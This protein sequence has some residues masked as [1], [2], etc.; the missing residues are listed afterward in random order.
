MKKRCSWC[1]DDPLY[2]DDHDNE[3]GVP[4][5][6]ERALFELLCLEGTC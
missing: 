2:Q 3:W 5:H 1:S 6:E 4:L